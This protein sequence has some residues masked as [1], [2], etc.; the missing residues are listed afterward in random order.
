MP[1]FLPPT[2]PGEPAW[3]SSFSVTLNN[4]AGGGYQDYSFRTAIPASAISISGS[5]IRVTLNADPA[6]PV[7]FDNVSIVE[8][9]GS[10]ADGTTTP[11]ELKFSGASGVAIAAGGTAVSDALAFSL[12][13]TKS[14][15]VIFDITT[16]AANAY[17]Y[18]ILSGD[19][20][21]FKAATNSYSTASVSGFSSSATQTWFVSK[22]EVLA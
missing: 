3:T 15:L 11:T 16:T 14:Y 18:R 1:I 20:T 12:D 9:S 6:Q 8:R 5:T 10:T 2:I 21:Y 22:I 4:A 13:E 19:I 7:T 17:G